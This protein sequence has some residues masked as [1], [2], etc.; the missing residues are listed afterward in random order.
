MGEDGVR[1]QAACETI[2]QRHRR[3]RTVAG[4]PGAREARMDAYVLIT[5]RHTDFIGAQA[6]PLTPFAAWRALWRREVDRAAATR[7]AV[8]VGRAQD[9]DRP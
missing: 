2:E 3:P 5:A 1:R 6:A 7:G 4:R 9:D 8:L